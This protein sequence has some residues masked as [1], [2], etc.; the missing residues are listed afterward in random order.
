[1]AEWIVLRASTP[2]SV[3]SRPLDE[4]L[5]PL[6][7]GAAQRRVN[8]LGGEQEGQKNCALTAAHAGELRLAQ[9]VASWA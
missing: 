3:A 5:E 7:R 8:G 2:P 6:D 1:M 9:K 4:L